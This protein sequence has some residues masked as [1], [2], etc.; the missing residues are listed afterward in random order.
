MRT[1]ERRSKPGRPAPRRA[2]GIA[3]RI[4]GRVEIPAYVRDHESFRQWARSPDCPE[5]LRVAF[6]NNG[7]WV[8]A[9]MEQFFAH[10]AVKAAFSVV[11]LPLALSMKL[12]RF[13]IEG[14]LFT[15]P[16]VGVSTIPDGFLISYESV[17]TGRL[18]KVRGKKNGCVEYEGTADMVLEVVSDSSEEKDLLD[19]AR[20]YWEA[21]VIEYWLAD[22]RTDPP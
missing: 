10:N 9:D 6:Y 7:L 1:V 12:G 20:L 16:R 4:A 19:L 14:M 13:A 2:A 22:A 18:R 8:D 17:R 21:G 5:K 3:V 11:L 15:N